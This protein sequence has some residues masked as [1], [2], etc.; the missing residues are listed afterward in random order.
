MGEQ[1]AIELIT[2]GAEAFAQ[3][4]LPGALDSFSDS[5]VWKVPG[6]SPLAGTYEG[7]DGLGRFFA[8]AFEKSQGTLTLELQKVLASGDHSVHFIRLSATRDGQDYS[9]VV[10][11]F[12]EHDPD[13]RT[14]RLWF[15]PDDIGAQDRLFA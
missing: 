7:H 4:N 11:N 14:R 2:A 9:I 5:I 15:L 1:Q 6:Q 12:G 3:G 10:A 8:A 13:G